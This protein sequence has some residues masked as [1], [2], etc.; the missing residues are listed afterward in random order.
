MDQAKGTAHLI[1]TIEKTTAPAS[2]NICNNAPKI[3]QTLFSVLA[4]P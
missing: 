2:A 3:G 1:N 4:K